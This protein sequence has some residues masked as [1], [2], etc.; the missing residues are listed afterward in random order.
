MA[1]YFKKKILH[2]DKKRM[3]AEESTNDNRRPTTRLQAQHY[4]RLG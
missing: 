2:K 1:E 4:I 3:T